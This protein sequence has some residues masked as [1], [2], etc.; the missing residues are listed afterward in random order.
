MKKLFPIV[1]TLLVLAA[2]G[3]AP[4]VD[5]EADKAA[6]QSLLDEAVAAENAG[7]L[8]GFVGGVA[9]DAVW[10]PPN[11]PPAVGKE[12][13]R[14]YMR[15]F[16]DQFNINGTTS[17]EEI[18]VVGDWAFVRG[19]WTYTL[20]PKGSGDPQEQSSSFVLIVRRQPDGSW[21]WSRAIWNS[22]LPAGGAAE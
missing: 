3:C 4:Q 9:D 8:A 13:V 1:A 19:I 14:G 5:V 20:T 10:L 11:E 18:Q 21:K 12:A 15:S 7:D 22:N 16:F 17:T 2:S 6:I